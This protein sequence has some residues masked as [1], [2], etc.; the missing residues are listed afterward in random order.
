MLI[1]VIAIVPTIAFSQKADSV[2]DAS[3]SPPTFSE[4]SYGDHHRQILDFWKAESNEPTP[5]VF[6][7]HGGGWGGGEKERVHRFVDVQPLLDAGISIVAINYRLIRHAKEDGVEPPVKACLY[8]A[9]RALQY[10]RSKA[11]EWN[12]NK[13]LIAAAGGSAGACTSLWLAFHPDL[14]DPDSS[15][16]VSRESTRVYCAGVKEPQT[17]LDPKQIREWIPNGKY[18]GHA[19]GKENFEEFLSDRESLLSLIAEYSPYSLVSADDP[20]IY[21]FYKNQPAIGQKV[22]NATHSSNYGVKLQ[23]RCVELGIDCEVQYPG[24]V[25]TTYQTQTDFLIGMLKKNKN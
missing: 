7:V 17:T 5:L 8:D 11:S 10:V 14:A 15:D 13:D 23:E 2:Y 20:S 1:G 16:P 21:M 24:A 3:V 18:G 25:G 19:F 9:A 6:V 22:D 4:I 12:I